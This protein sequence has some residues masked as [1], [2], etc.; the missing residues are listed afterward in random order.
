MGTAILDSIWEAIEGKVNALVT[1]RINRFH[2]ALI[3]RGQ[4]DPAPK[5]ADPEESPIPEVSNHCNQ[6]Y[7]V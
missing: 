3:E 4:I 2:D 5:P 6:D 7:A 1:R